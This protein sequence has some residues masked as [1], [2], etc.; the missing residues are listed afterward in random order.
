MGAPL[1]SCT[2]ADLSRPWEPIN[3]STVGTRGPGRAAGSESDPPHQAWPWWSSAPSDPHLALPR[4]AGWAP[5]GVAARSPGTARAHCSPHT[6]ERWEW[7]RG[8]PSSAGPPHT[9]NAAG[10]DAGRLSGWCSGRTECGAARNADS[11]WGKKAGLFGAAT[12]PAELTNRT[13]PAPSQPPE[14]PQ[15]RA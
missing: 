1:L 5:P 11:R 12:T 4:P 6:E 15:L 2:S 9:R 7:G 13:R 3:F 10:R 14:F 8:S